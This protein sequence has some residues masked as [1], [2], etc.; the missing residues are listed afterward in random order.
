M[1]RVQFVKFAQAGYGYGVTDENFEIVAQRRQRVHI[2]LPTLHHLVHCIT[3]NK[4]VRATFG[5]SGN[6]AQAVA[7][8]DV[9]RD[10]ASDFGPRTRVPPRFSLQRDKPWSHQ[11]PLCNRYALASTPELSVIMASSA[12]SK[13]TPPILFA[14]RS[15]S[16]YITINV[17]DVD[18]S[19]AKI[20]LQA[21]KLTFT[22]TSHGKEYAAELEFF[23]EVDPTDKV[24]KPVAK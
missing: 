21:N 8:A 7:L 4:L 16:V 9:G 19:T 6:C 10:G 17:A 3:L 1:K 23:A 14:Q 24:R 11:T 20:D 15:D 5:K 18:A 2:W 13:N 12:A 22:G